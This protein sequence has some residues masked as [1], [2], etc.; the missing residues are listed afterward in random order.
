[1][2]LTVSVFI[3]Y[4]CVSF[5]YWIISHQ[6]KSAFYTQWHLGIEEIRFYQ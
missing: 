3:S 1:M 6:D 5:L 2:H 4:D